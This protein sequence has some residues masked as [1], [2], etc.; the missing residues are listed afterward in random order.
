MGAQEGWEQRSGGFD[1]AKDFSIDGGGAEVTAIA[2]AKIRVILISIV[3]LR[4]LRPV[5]APQ[6]RS[7][8]AAFISALAF[9]GG[10]LNASFRV[11][12][13]PC[14]DIVVNSLRTRGA[15]LRLSSSTRPIHRLHVV[16]IMES[17]A[18]SRGSWSL[19]VRK[20]GLREN[21]E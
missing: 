12:P 10:S 14:G 17:A 19:Q 2:S 6:T 7:H 4:L 16:V 8:H 3:M 15:I 5:S 11:G 18:I 13:W 21:K 1:C 9:E 20:R